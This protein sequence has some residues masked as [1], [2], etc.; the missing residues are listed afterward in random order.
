MLTVKTFLKKSSI[1]GLGL[2]AGEDIPKGRIVWK[3]VKGFD[4]VVKQGYINKLPRHTQEWVHKYGYLDNKK[5]GYVICLD[6]ARFFNH[7]NNPNTLDSSNLTIANR[8]IKKGEELT[9]NYFEFDQ[10]ASA[11][12]KKC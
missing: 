10:D 2:F 6:D 4:I 8:R 12:I 1:H 9:C 5:G 7:S 11:K 3:F